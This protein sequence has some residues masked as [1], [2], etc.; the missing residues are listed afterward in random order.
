MSTAQFRIF[1]LP[2][3]M[4]NELTRIGTIA[5][6]FRNNKVMIAAGEEGGAMSVVHQGVINRAYADFNGAPEVVFEGLSYS[7]F[8]A[9]M[10]PVA[11]RSYKGPT[12][13]AKVMADLAK[14][15]GVA[16]ERNGVSVILQ[17]PY[18]PGTSWTQ[19][20]S[21]ADAA[22]LEYTLDKGLLAIWNRG[23][24]RKTDNPVRIAVDTGMVGYPVYTSNG[25]Q[26]RTLFNPDIGLGKI[27]EVDTTL[28]PAKGK[29]HVYGVAHTLESETPNGQWFTDIAC[30]KGLIDG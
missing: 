8:D 10:K 21:C 20:Q 23:G 15:M 24:S 9:A 2:L 5:N 7:G 29:W 14:D 17:N 4:M 25:I 22:R 6:G 19:L 13:A 27:I 30:S 11:A 12:D 18:F 26:V 3:G 16:F 28:T 1:G